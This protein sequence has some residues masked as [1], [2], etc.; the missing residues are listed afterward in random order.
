MALQQ[1]IQHE[2]GAYS[3]YW[4]VIRT[5]LNY[6]SNEAEIELYGY[7]SEQA[8][9]DGKSKLDKRIFN[10]QGSEFTTYFIPSSIDPQDINQVKNAYLYIKGISGGE[11][12]SA[13][14]V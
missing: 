8:R 6:E 7:V 12:T 9:L 4:R 11:F 13:T 2:T 5:D 3:Q 10:T 14:D 1:I